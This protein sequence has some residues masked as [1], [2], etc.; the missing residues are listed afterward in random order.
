MT[1]GIHVFSVKGV[2]AV[3]NTSTTP[4][5]FSWVI[6]T[7]PS[8][9]TI[10][11]PAAGS[12]I[13]GTNI[14]ITGTAYDV[15]SDVQK[16]EV[17]TDDGV[18]WLPA[19][20]TT[21]WSY[22]W[23]V[24]AD[25]SYSIKSRATDRAG[26]VEVPKPGINLTVYRRQPS[27]I[28]TSGR[29]LTMNS[30]PFLVKGVV[31]SPVPIG[32]DPETMPPY[33]DYFTSDYSNI[34]SRDLPLLRQMGANAVS[35][36]SWGGSADHR[37]FL[38]K[39][40]NAGTDSIYVIAGFWIN[41]GQDIDPASAN[42]VRGQ[43]KANFRRM[44]AT[45]K[46]H[47]AILMWAIGNNLNDSSL[48]GGDL[49]NLFS[50]ID[51]MAAEAH[52]E[53]G[54][55]FHPVT[56]ALTDSALIS[57]ISTYNSA[58]PSLDLWGVNVYRGNSFGTL[59]SDYQAVSSKPLA[60]LEY[61]IDSFDDVNGD[62]YEKIGTPYQATYA[63]ALWNE[64]QSNAN[65]CVGGIIM[66][67]SDEWWQGKY[68]TDSACQDNDPAVHSD[69]GQ[70]MASSPD[71]Y[72]N[73]EWWGIMRP[74]LNTSGADIME[75]RA[76]YYTLR[77]LWTGVTPATYTVTPSAGSGGSISPAVA[78][79]VTSGATASFTITPNSGYHITSISGCGGTA[80]GVQQ[81][82]AP[83]TYTT[84]LI[85]ADCTVTATFSNT[86]TV[87]PSA[88]SGGSIS[89]NTPQTLNY[90]ATRSFTVTP[91][92]GYSILSVTG[93][94]GTL[95]GNTYTTGPI[96]ADCTVTASFGAP[97][98]IMT[99][100]SGPTTGGLGQNV[101]FS[102]IVKNQGTGWSS[103]FNVRFYL[104]TDGTITTSDQAVCEVSISGG[105]AAGA[106]QT[107]SCTNSIPIQTPGVYTIGA[108]ADWNS[109]ALETNETNN[110]LAGNQITISP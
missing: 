11:S 29:Q 99:S 56:A 47:P 77:N 73:A 90:N 70:A 55:G 9:S 68:S 16:V 65:V 19:D 97:D 98:L 30:A 80:V 74:R 110:A 44:V 40:Y 93:C 28:A 63:A 92:T 64:I 59:F 96:T 8:V 91:N 49:N 3:G 105:L 27:N 67:Y 71:G 33:G 95:A 22:S 5:N 83:F 26:N 79:T 1:E 39:A 62:E 75:P 88:G 66:E 89:P 10:E 18:T 76:V 46:N 60:V 41:P 14:E 6:D 21:I 102:G 53:E 72:D 35:I 20:G 24:P 103:G 54:A 107:V 36:S 85:T 15:G 100:V 13:M 109:W 52:A 23:A 48:Y 104:S 38:D 87:T 4:A 106:Q 94:G 81:T 12:S 108:I 32:A 37:D 58:V 17:S 101:T 34:Y 61:G 45:H 57:T 86:Y 50:L 69:C 25:G 51:E 78:Q 82:N 31:Y 84:G 42:N 2:D 7:I 43:I